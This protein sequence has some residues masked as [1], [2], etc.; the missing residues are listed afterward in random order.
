[1]VVF[2]GLPEGRLGE[3]VIGDVNDYAQLWVV[4]WVGLESLLRYAF[5]SIFYLILLFIWL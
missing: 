5:I 1:M 3:V 4:L 2:G